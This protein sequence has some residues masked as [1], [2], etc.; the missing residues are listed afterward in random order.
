MAAKNSVPLG[1]VDLPDGPK[2]IYP[3]NDIF[4]NYTFEDMEYW[5][6]L[7]LA[8]N[9]IIE[10]YKRYKLETKVLAHLRRIRR[11]PEC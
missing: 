8:T 7:R 11:L 10:A 1:Y 4:L 9:L 3:M 6:A 5:E 2:A